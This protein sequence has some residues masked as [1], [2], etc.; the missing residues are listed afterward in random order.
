MH[1]SV[2]FS[3]FPPWASNC[4][5]NSP[6]VI[7]DMFKVALELDPAFYT[8]KLTNLLIMLV[9]KGRIFQIN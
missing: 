7:T 5:L 6:Q 2:I 1:T 8:M 3:F 4:C 9:E